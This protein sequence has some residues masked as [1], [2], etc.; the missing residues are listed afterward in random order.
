[1]VF[2]LER[3]RVKKTAKAIPDTTSPESAYILMDV[4]SE[5]NLAGVITTGRDNG[6]LFV[7]HPLKIYVSLI[8]R[9]TKE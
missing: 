4:V 3:K 5:N 2:K 8:K 1:M 9:Q 7:L 6:K